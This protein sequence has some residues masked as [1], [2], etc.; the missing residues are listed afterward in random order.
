[1]TEFVRVKETETGAKTMAMQKL[2][3]DR[4]KQLVDKE[5]ERLLVGEGMQKLSG[6][7]QK[8]NEQLKKLKKA[9]KVKEQVSGLVV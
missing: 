4:E 7:V 2:L 3:S 1:M 8:K 5:G 9:L 6:A